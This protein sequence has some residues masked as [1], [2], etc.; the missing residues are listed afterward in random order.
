MSLTMPP[1]PLAT[2]PPDAT[3]YTISGP[4]HRLLRTEFPR[5]VR[6][7]FGGVTVLDTTNGA[8]VHESNLLPALYVPADDVD[9]DV[10]TPT[11]HSTHCPFKGDASYWS[12]TAGDR[13]A[14]NAVWAYEQPIDDAGWL[15]GWFAFYWDRLDRWFDEDEEVFGHLRDPFHRVDVRPSKRRVHVTIDGELIAESAAAKVLSETGLP[16]RWYLP[17]RDVRT[18]VLTRSDTS[19]HCPYKGQSTYWSTDTHDDIAWSYP[20][21]FDDARRVAG[22][23]SFDGDDVQVE[24]AATH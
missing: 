8:L 20:E 16:N 22:H 13:T 9:T 17:E 1:G 3:N 15:Q 10:L 11:D 19:T 6:A 18:D 2:T 4:P 5:R 14:E 24:V 12:I 7:D 21:P 23:L